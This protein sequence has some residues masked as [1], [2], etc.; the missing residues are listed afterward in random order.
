MRDVATAIVEALK[1][2]VTEGKAIELAGPKVYT[3][4]TPSRTCFQIPLTAHL[5]VRPR[6]A[7]QAGAH[8]GLGTLCRRKQLLELTYETIREKYGGVYAPLFLLKLAAKPREWLLKRVRVCSLPFPSYVHV[9]EPGSS[10]SVSTKMSAE[11]AVLCRA[12]L[13]QRIQCLWRT[14]WKS[15]RTTWCWSLHLA[16]SPSQTWASSRRA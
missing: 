1:T 5:P 8:H 6:G 7:C 3:Y 12:L 9:R 10:C 11:T 13:F 14:T 16:S 2:K 15:P 4:A